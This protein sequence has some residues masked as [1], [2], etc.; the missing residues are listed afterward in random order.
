MTISTRLNSFLSIHKVSY[1]VIDHETSSSS[2]GSALKAEVPLNEI[3]K[4]VILENHEG[5]KLMAVLP[6]NNKI[7][8]SRLNEDLM[9]DYHLVKEGEIRHMFQ[10]CEI[11]AIPPIG[12]AFNVNVVFDDKL[13]EL[14]HV[15]IE[16]GDH[17]S[18]LKLSATDFIQLMRSAKHSRF[19]HEVYH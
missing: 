2:V 18:L 8:L 11:G 3:A 1:E 12:Y 9:G 19:S 15:Y 14:S 5:R 7:S 16:A 10:D 4:A 6:A 13:E 17:E